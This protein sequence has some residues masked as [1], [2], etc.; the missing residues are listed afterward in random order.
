MTQID[1]TK[2]V[3]VTGANGYVASWLV[4]R[5]LDEGIT[6]HAAVRNPT[7]LSKVSHLKSIA[8]GSKGKL[9]FFKTDLLTK[10]TYKEAMEGCELVYHTASPFTTAIKDPQKE[11]IDPAVNGTE[12]VLETVNQTPSVKRVV[13]T[14]SCAA[15]YTDAIDS[16]NAPDGRLTEKIW[17]STA[18]LE[19]QP[20]SYSKTLAEKLA[21]EMSYSQNRWNLITIN[22]C[23]V[24]GPA[25]NPKTATSESINVL[26]LFGNGDMKMGV[27]KMGTGVVDV[28]DV[29]EAHF[30]AGFT[31]HAQGRY[32]TAGHNTDF[33]EM[34]KVLLPRY[35]A[36]FPLPKRALPK[37]LLMLIGPLANPLFTRKFIR[38]NVNIP[39]NADNSKII[40]DLGMTFR[41]LQVTME[42]AFQVLIDEKIIKAK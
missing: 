2:P 6:V 36:K 40:N 5:L 29:A 41:P 34:S 30:R 32:I 19:Y 12:N 33:L 27:P 42:D 10:G 21:W 39:W 23:L 18:S 37:G 1:R 22:P 28:R 8:A 26:K 16:V 9:R 35:G 38:N 3:L 25:L 13:V 17:N 11:L 4:K 7:D 24:L 31:P 15:I 20:Y 14:S